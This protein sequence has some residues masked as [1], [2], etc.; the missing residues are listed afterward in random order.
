MCG[1]SKLFWLVN[2]LVFLGFTSI[3]VLVNNLYIN[4]L[5][6]CLLLVQVDV[7]IGSVCI[8]Y[9]LNKTEEG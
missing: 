9:F 8:E 5:M 7:V 4:V 6:V 3:L 1:M 2:L